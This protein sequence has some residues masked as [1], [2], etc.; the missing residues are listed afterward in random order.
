MPWK[1][2]TLVLEYENCNSNWRDICHENSI[3]HAFVKVSS[4]LLKLIIDFKEN[5]TTDVVLSSSQNLKPMPLVVSEVI[6]S[7]YEIMKFLDSRE[8]VLLCERNY[9]RILPQMYFADV[10]FDEKT[11]AILLEKAL[12]GDTDYMSVSYEKIIFLTLKY[13]LIWIIVHETEVIMDGDLTVLTETQ[14]NFF[15]FYLEVMKLKEKSPIFKTMFLFVDSNEALTAVISDI[16]TFR[17]RRA[18]FMIDGSIFSRDPTKEEIFLASFPSLNPFVIDILLRFHCLN[19]LMCMTLG[20]LLDKYSSIPERFL[21]RFHH[22]VNMNIDTFDQLFQKSDD[23]DD[24]EFHCSSV[25]SDGFEFHPKIPEVEFS[26]P[27]E[28]YADSAEDL[29]C[30]SLYKHSL[31]DFE[32]TLEEIDRDYFACKYSPSFDNNT[33]IDCSANDEEMDEVYVQP[34]VNRNFPSSLPFAKRIKIENKNTVVVRPMLET[35]KWSQSD[36]DTEK[37]DRNNHSHQDD[38]MEQNFLGCSPE[39]QNS[40]NFFRT[41]ANFHKNTQSI[42]K[43]SDIK[44]FMHNNSRNYQPLGMGMSFPSSVTFSQENKKLSNA[45]RVNKGLC[46][47]TVSKLDIIQ[48]AATRTKSDVE[49]QRVSPIVFKS[50]DYFCNS[51]KVVEF[52]DEKYRETTPKKKPKFSLDHNLLTDSDWVGQTHVRLTPFEGK[53]LQYEKIPGHKG[54]T[55]LVFQ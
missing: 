48:N 40:S 6:A 26:E 36:V 9:K 35:S 52:D 41:K 55:R 54:Q 33:N 31:N 1:D 49:T 29:S 30:T 19:D 23:E 12:L 8:D 18:N 10:A 34:K 28:E 51:K 45:V 38:P 32:K 43:I 13:E 14:A 11:A 25:K 24:E 3:P 44:K 15:Q 50:A 20:T 22:A 39:T 16:L 21:S 46:S 42:N 7:N 37:L 53:R 27:V 2:A 17:L 4:S 47:Q 5:R